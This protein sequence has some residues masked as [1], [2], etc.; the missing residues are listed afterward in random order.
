LSYIK[1]TGAALK[2]I[3]KNP[4]PFVGN[5]V[6]AAKTGFLNFADHFLEHLKAGLL[7]WLLGALP[8][9]YIPK[10]FELGE[11]VKFVFSVLGLSWQNIRGKLVKVVGETV[12]TAMETGFDIVVTL[13]KEGP[14]AAWDKVKEELSKL[15]ET[16]IGG[17]IDFVVDTVV[18][19]AIPK[20]IAMF[21]PGAGFISAILSIYD[22]IMVFV[23][24]ISKIIQVVTAFLDSIV[25]IAAGAIDAAAAKVESILAN[26]LSLSI[27]FLAGFIGLG[28]VADKIMGVIGKVRAAVD[29]AIDALIAWIVKMAKGLFG[30]AK[31]ALTRWWDAKATVD[32][33]G[34]THTLYF[35]G[36]GD[37]AKPYIKASPGRRISE[38]LND[39]WKRNGD[40]DR[41]LAHDL[42]RQLEA[43]RPGGQEEATYGPKRVDWNNQLAAVLLKLGGAEPAPPSV[44][45]YEGTNEHG[46]GKSV[47][48]TILSKEHPKG[49]RPGDDAPVW[50]NLKDLGLGLGKKLRSPWY[51]Q[52][53][54]LNHN[55]GGPGLRHNL[56]P[57]TQKANS[58][59]KNNVENELKDLVHAPKGAVIYYR[60]TAKAP[61]PKG[62][63]PR[64]ATLN[65]TYSAVRGLNQG[66]AS[67]FVRYAGA[68]GDFNPMHHD[69]TIA[70]QVGNPSVF[71]HGMLSMGLAAR[72]VKDWFGP[73]A[74]RVLK[75]RFAKQVWPGDVLTCVA[76][77]TGT[78][79]EN[80]ETLVDLDLSVTNQNGDRAI[81]RRQCSSSAATTLLRTTSFGSP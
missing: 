5:L 25:A 44:I 68:S 33:E 60:V 75:V 16:V 52:G 6:R 49:S 47:E 59:H 51:V 30:K 50:E 53:H 8:G 38:Y 13:V 31:A 65:A 3:L 24:K 15:Q 37:E 7:D 21:I 10:A 11:I 55:L 17:I 73:E 70:T 63:N 78:H 18:K 76:T 61:P 32:I 45:T 22:T 23:E 57:I 67:D 4:L 48:A 43:P 62:G 35:E 2:S 41:D 58:D 42:A 74:V 19:K 72:V 81:T 64:L 77:V 56:T 46:G 54:L 34:T 14:A 39:K 20:L 12:V 36:E 9:V 66:I 69:D 80:G 79:D 28:K 71:G 26:L 40:K 1:R 27:S 29:K